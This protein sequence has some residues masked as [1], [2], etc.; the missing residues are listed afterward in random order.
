[1]KCDNLCVWSS[2]IRTVNG[3]HYV[4]VDDT[5]EDRVITEPHASPRSYDDWEKKEKIYCARCPQDWGIKAN[6]KSVPCSVIKIASFVIVDPY[7][8]RSYYKRWK[9]VVL[10]VAE[11]SEQDMQDLREYALKRATE[12]RNLEI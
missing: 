3:R 6:Y 11:L 1:L 8:K 12:I 10:P 2:D 4:V 9:E 7:E 5:F